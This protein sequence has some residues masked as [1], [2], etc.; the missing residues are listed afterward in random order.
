M[1]QRDDNSTMDLFSASSSKIFR[2]CDDGDDVTTEI[3][4]SKQ[5]E[6]PHARLEHKPINWMTCIQLSTLVLLYLSPHGAKAF[7][8]GIVNTRKTRTGDPKPISVTA[9]QRHDTLAPSLWRSRDDEAQE[10]KSGMSQTSW[11]RTGGSLRL[12][13]SRY[14]ENNDPEDDD[15][16]DDDDTEDTNEGRMRKRDRIKDWFTSSSSSTS[17]MGDDSRSRI[18]TKLDNLFS[19]MPSLGEIL[20]DRPDEDTSSNAVEE[21]RRGAKRDPD[22]FEE[23]KKRILDR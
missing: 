4:T 13:S 11:W 21:V 20:A 2:R 8:P 10:L 19:G 14:G 16:D 12:F 23:E 6:I 9:G 15:D 18:K 5:I 1:K 3:S 7:S 22:W 17:D